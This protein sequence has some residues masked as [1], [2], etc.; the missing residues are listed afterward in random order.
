ML[1]NRTRP[2]LGG[3]RERSS[4]YKPRPA[5]PPPLC[6]PCGKFE[7]GPLWKKWPV[8]FFSPSPCRMGG[9]GGARGFSVCLALPLV[10][11]V[12]CLFFFSLGATG[13]EMKPH[14]GSTGD[15]KAEEDSRRHS[16]LWYAGERLP[17][18]AISLVPACEQN[19]W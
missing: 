2:L 11:L 16:V 8:G 17:A 14:R 6:K 12:L 13:R 15:C 7:L 1:A 9:G 19:L 5:R 18:L 10:F 3:A 4:A